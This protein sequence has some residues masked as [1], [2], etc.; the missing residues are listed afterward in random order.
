MASGSFKITPIKTITEP[1]LAQINSG[2][3]QLATDIHRL[4]TIYAPRDSGALV[5]SGRIEKIDGGYAVAFGGSYGISDVR[6]AKRRHYENK[7]N[8]GTLRYL[9]RAGDQTVKQDRKYFK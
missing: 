3:L 8:P 9:E 1:K 4:A 5:S 7:K 6:Y 2:L